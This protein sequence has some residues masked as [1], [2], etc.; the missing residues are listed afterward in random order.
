MKQ[1]VQEGVDYWFYLSPK[2]YVVDKENIF[3]YH[4]ESGARLEVTEGHLK[5]LLQAVYEP[6]NLG[7][8]EFPQELWKQEGAH[9]LIEQM[10][11]LHM[12]GLIPIDREQ[13]KPINLL[14]ILN[15]QKDVDKAMSIGELSLVV[16][17]LLSYLSRLMLCLGGG[18]RL[19]L[20]YLSRVWREQEAHWMSPSLLYSLL[21]Q[22]RYSRMK[23]VGLYADSLFLHPQIKEIL[24]LLESYEY[25]YQLW[26]SANHYLQNQEEIKMYLRSMKCICHLSLL[27]SATEL[28]DLARMCEVDV[29]LFSW[30]FLIEDESQYARVEQ[31]TERWGIVQS[32]LV[33]IYTG[34]NLPFFEE[35]VYLSEDD[36]F[37]EPIEMRRVFCNQKLNSNDFGALTV[38]PTGECRVS[39]N[40]PALG[41]LLQSSLLEIL[42]KELTTNTAWRKTR[43]SA[44]CQ[45]CLFQ[46]LCPP[47]SS[48]EQVIGREDLC[49][50]P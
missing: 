7:V 28:E 32:E 16:D 1:L 21:E 50:L 30:H 13:G 20:S 27:A 40:T 36:I 49:R 41:N 34:D 12:A 5:D 11:S 25:D 19:C 22:A 8:V 15:L 29:Q 14:P 45:K 39:M 26:M 43:N 17:D 24:D 18:G 6:K 9:V 23:Q 42:Y 10:L 4:T 47:P 35:Y 44:K 48:Y 2:V 33:P 46:Y 38:L 3:L 37:S 31:F